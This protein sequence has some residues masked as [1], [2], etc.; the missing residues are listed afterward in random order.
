[1]NDDGHPLPIP[2]FLRNVL[3]SQAVRSVPARIFGLGVLRE[4]VKI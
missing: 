1:V 4:R 3:K 2:P